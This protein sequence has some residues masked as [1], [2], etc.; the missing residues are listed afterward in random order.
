MYSFLFFKSW[1]GWLISCLFLTGRHIFL[2]AVA[3]LLFHSFPLICVYSFCSTWIASVYVNTV[4]YILF[5][6][7]ILFAWNVYFDLTSN[8]NWLNDLAS[9]ISWLI[10]SYQEYQFIKYCQHQ[11]QILR[12]QTR[13]KNDSQGQISMP[14]FVIFANKRI[15]ILL[16]MNILMKVI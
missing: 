16:I 1:D 6:V 10:W 9:N 15:L 2:V 12:K 8:I 4:S 13:N 11:Q 14:N 5:G 7:S 3:I